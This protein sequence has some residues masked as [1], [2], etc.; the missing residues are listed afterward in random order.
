V[1]PE[2]V[3]IG[4][5]NHDHEADAG[6]VRPVDEG[7]IFGFKQRNGVVKAFHLE[8]GGRAHGGRGGR[9]PE[10]GRGEH[11]RAYVV[12]DPV[13]FRE[14]AVHGRFEAEQ[15]LIEIAGTLLVRDRIGDEGDFVD[16]DH[17]QLL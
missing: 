3:A 14:H 11:A 1:N 12:L 6:F 4:I 17:G 16:L 10:I 13:A 5:G 9:L 7:H 2:G 15:T 8:R